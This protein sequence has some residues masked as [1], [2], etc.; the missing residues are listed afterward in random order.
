MHSKTMNP[1]DRN[2][3]GIVQ[4]MRGCATNRCEEGT[5]K[6]LVSSCYGDI[7]YI[8][9]ESHGAPLQASKQ[10]KRKE[11]QQT[12]EKAREASSQLAG[13]RE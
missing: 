4:S 7:E 3:A 5:V 8:V 10:K 1:A 13:T 9:S 6:G 2:I 12:S 11:T